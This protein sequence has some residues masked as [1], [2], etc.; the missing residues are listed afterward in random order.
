MKR[1]STKERVWHI[2]LGAMHDFLD[3]RQKTGYIIIEGQTI[4]IPDGYVPNW[5]FTNISL[6]GSTSGLRYLRQGKGFLPAE[7]PDYDFQKKKIGHVWHYRI[8]PIPEYYLMKF[9]PLK[10]SKLKIRFAEGE[11]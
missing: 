9:K 3:V 5:V 10:K 11:L 7:H 8:R 1:K 4:P 6:C 2:L